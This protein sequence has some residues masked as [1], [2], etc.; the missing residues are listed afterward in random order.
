MVADYVR[1]RG[2]S[3]EQV[4]CSPARRTLETLEGVAPAGERLIEPELYGA[5]AAE[6]VERLRRVPEDVGSVMLIGHNPA[7]QILV[8]RLVDVNGPQ[9]SGADL[10]EVQR[11]FPTGALAT[12]SL[13]CGWSEL[14]RGCA[15]LISFVRPKALR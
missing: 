1:E 7:M 8:L 10:A 6:I 9:T 5:S 11:K 2:I 15:Q 12:L 13:R 3:P 14:G 4:L